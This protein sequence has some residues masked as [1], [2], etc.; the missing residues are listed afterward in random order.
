MQTFAVGCFGLSVSSYL[1]LFYNH[2]TN[3]MNS[4]VDSLY[5]DKTMKIVIDI[6]ID[7]ILLS[8]VRQGYFIPANP[9]PSQSSSSYKKTGKKCLFFASQQL[10]KL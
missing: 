8:V 2:R 5:D 10:I 9:Q 3:Q 1:E 6:V 7:F 4:R